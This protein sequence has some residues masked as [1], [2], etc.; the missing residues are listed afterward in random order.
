LNYSPQ[1]PFRGATHVPKTVSLVEG[2][3]WIVE[4]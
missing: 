2:T 1:Q 4:Q 3:T